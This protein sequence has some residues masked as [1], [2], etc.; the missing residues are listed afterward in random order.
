SPSP[1]FSSM[2]VTSWP[3][4]A[5]KYAVVTP[6]TPPPRTSVFIAGA[7]CIEQEAGAHGIRRIEEQLAHAGEI[8]GAGDLRRNRRPALDADFGCDTSGEIEAEQP[9][10]DERRA[11][12]HEPPMMEQRHACAGAGAARRGVDLARTPDERIRRDAV[13][14]GQLV[15]E[16]VVDGGFAH[17]GDV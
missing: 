15:D 8:R 5:R 3:A 11:G 14:I 7:S 17:A 2:S 4:F 6:T 13:R 10:A 1:G 12:T 16:D 9:A